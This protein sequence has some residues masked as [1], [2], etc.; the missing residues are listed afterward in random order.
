MNSSAFP[1][2]PFF[3]SAELCKARAEI[4]FPKVVSD[5]LILAPSLS[6]WPVAPVELARSDP[7]K[8]T[9]LVE[10]GKRREEKLRSGSR[11][12]QRGRGRGGEGT[13]DEPDTRDFF[14]VEIC[15]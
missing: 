14:G 6:R 10:V 1:F 7:A 2:F 12:K 15:V 4:T 13:P 9:K 8:S 5:L 3:V 11:E